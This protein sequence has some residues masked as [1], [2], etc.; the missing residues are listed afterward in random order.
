MA[1]IG[2]SSFLESSYLASFTPLVVSTPHG[3]AVVHVNPS[4]SLYFVQRHT[5]NPAQPYSPPH[6]INKRAIMAALSQLSVRSVVA[7]GSVG[8]LKLSI[9]V[10]QLLLPDDFYDA[11]PVSMFDFDKRGHMSDHHTHHTQQTT[12]PTQQPSPPRETMT[13]MQCSALDPHENTHT[14]KICTDPTSHPLIPPPFR[15]ALVRPLG[16][17]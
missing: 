11:E 1:L 10:G 14:S 3:P 6:L 13:S 2:G 17:H 4:Q 15:P 12:Q 7:F 16:L 5:A 9:P 8:S